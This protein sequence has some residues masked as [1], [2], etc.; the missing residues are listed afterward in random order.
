MFYCTARYAPLSSMLQKAFRLSL[1][2]AAVG[3]AMSAAQASPTYHFKRNMQTLKISDTSSTPVST[4]EVL[5]P[6]KGDVSTPGGA[7][8]G[9]VVVGTSATR[10]AVFRNIGQATATGL[11][12]VMTGTGL[13]VSDECGTPAKPISLAGGAACTVTMTYAPTV[14]GPSVGT[15]KFTSSVENNPI[16]LNPILAQ[17]VAPYE[18][19][20]DLR[21]DSASVV[22]STGNSLVVQNGVAI[23]TTF[24]KSGTGALSFNNRGVNGYVKAAANVRYS[25]GQADLTMEAW[26]RPTLMAQNAILSNYPNGAWGAGAWTLDHN[27]AAAPRK[28]SFFIYGNGGSPLLASATEPALSAWTHVAVTRSGSTWRL[29]VNGRLES[30]NTYS[31]ALDGA[32]AARELAVGLIENGGWDWGYT[33]QMDN[34]RVT[35]GLARYTGNFTPSN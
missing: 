12:A 35:R 14:A 16:T 18:T 2:A 10:T 29:F 22:D 6:A 19:V 31:G 33:G 20:M 13:T 26:I 27:H 3:F 15:L 34:V 7:D 30:T 23:T 11:Q 5:T 4:P 8:F 28:V 32:S 17:A 24:A 21:G 9:F 25:F 1:I